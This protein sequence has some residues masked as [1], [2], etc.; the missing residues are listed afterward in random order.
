M[1]AIYTD[2]YPIEND[3]VENLRLYDS[4][5]WVWAPLSAIRTG[6]EMAHDQIM[7]VG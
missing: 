1:R 2:I 3:T 6:Y 7:G 5:E 4:S